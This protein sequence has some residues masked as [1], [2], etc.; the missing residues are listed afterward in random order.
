MSAYAS[1]YTT[2][3]TRREAKAHIA[4]MEGWPKARAVRVNLIV[5]C[6]DRDSE[7]GI[8]TMKPYWVI[9]ASPGQFL[10]YSGY[11]L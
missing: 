7:D 1:D 8:D 9:E 11:V 4:T 2:F 3:R 6:D 5:P 10:R